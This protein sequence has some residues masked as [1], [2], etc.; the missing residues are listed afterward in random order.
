MNYMEQTVF[1]DAQ[2]HILNMASHIKTPENLD[3]LKDQLSKFYAKLIDEEMELLWQSGE[4][5]ET[6]LANL[7]GSHHRTPYK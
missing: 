1:N 2:L 3:R 4:L 6:K 7:R 5:T